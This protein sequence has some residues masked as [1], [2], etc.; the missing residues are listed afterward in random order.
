MTD[1]IR[2]LRALAFAVLLTPAALARAAAPPGSDG[3]LTFRIENDTLNGTDQYYTA[4]QRIG[5]TSP[6]GQVP[7]PLARLGSWLW[8]E[9]RQRI[10]LGLTQ[11]LFT[12]RQTQIDPP[13]PRDR[14][15][16]GL[17]LGG[18]SLIHDTAVRRDVV[19]LDLGM[20]GPASLAEQSQ[21]TF[22]HLIGE[23][24][25]KGWDAQLPNQPVVEVTAQRIW[26]VPLAEPGALR[27]DLLPELTGAVGSWRVA[28]QFGAVLRIGQGLGADFGAPRIRSGLTGDDAYTATRHLAWYVFVGAD[29]Q[30]VAWD[31]TLQ[32]EPFR[33]TAHVTRLPLVGEVEAGIAVI[34]HGIRASFTHV[35][36]T[37]T[38][39]GQSGGVFQF[40]SVSLSVPF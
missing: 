20:I 39:R 18:L 8:G 34:T 35:I 15:Y 2:I 23:A 9:G 24:T 7:A 22:H 30:A 40:D 21:D 1:P 10:G 29:G 36:R 31:E 27:I 17:L 13:D 14:P 33:S 19:Q 25:P 6:V 38:F 26:R 12:P 4:G 37:R 28:G 32:G 5:W 16:A 11:L 3:I